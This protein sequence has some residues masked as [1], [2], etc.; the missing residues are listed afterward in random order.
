MT[1]TNFRLS[2][3]LSAIFLLHR[4]LYRFFLR[5]RSNLRSRDASRFRHRNP[6]IARSLISKPAPAIGASLAGFALAIYPADQLRITI[7]VYAAT[8]SLEFLYNALESDGWFIKRP[9]WWGSWMLTPLATGQLLYAFVFDRD[10]VPKVCICNPNVIFICDCLSHQAY[11][12]FILNH[13][14]NYVQK[15]PLDYP[16]NLQ[17]PSTDAIVDGLNEMSR[18]NWP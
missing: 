6:R 7:A 4:L 15:R 8:R 11:T 9:R 18:L 17:W 13:T 14:P 1:S 12:D 3:S 10:C 5:L 16:A 2:V